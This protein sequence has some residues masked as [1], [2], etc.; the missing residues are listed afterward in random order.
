MGIDKSLF[1]RVGGMETL[2]KVHKIFYDKLFAHPWLKQYFVDHPQEIFENQ[3]T[4]FMA[5]LFGGPKV[6]AGKTPKMAH[7]NIVITEEL[8]ELRSQILSE[9]IRQA[10]IS[11]ELREEW[12][13]ADRTLKSAIVK[14]DAS[15]CRKMFDTQ[16][17]FDIP[18]PAGLA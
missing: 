14:K 2:K 11:D 12:L 1:D 4:T 3:Q 9:S 6:Y 5:G 13:D 15:E 10:G 16:T 18:K 17:I 8:F 7:Q